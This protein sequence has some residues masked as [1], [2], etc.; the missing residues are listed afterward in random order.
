MLR[1]LNVAICSRATVDLSILS[2]SFVCGTVGGCQMGGRCIF[3]MLLQDVHI[4]LHFLYRL[5]SKSAMIQS[6][7]CGLAERR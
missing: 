3:G 4:K 6:T 2:L 7:I 5:L 1:T